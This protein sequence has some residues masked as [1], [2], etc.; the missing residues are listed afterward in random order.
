[1]K[2]SDDFIAAVNLETLPS[3]ASKDFVTL[4][5]ASVVF[6]IDL[7]KVAINVFKSSTIVLLD[8]TLS[9]NPSLNLLNKA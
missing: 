8:S 4:F 1:M 3:S 2:I 6:L 5:L 7:S 9:A